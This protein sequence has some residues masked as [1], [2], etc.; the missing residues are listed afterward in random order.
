VAEVLSLCRVL[1]QFQPS[2]TL[3]EDHHQSLQGR[4]PGVVAP[5]RWGG[6]VDVGVGRVGANH[7]V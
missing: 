4:K 1:E 6:G 3:F 2:S 7:P 5:K